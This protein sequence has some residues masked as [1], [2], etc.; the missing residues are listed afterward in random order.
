MRGAVGLSGAVGL[1]GEIR[2]TQDTDSIEVPTVASPARLPLTWRR[3]IPLVS[4]LALTMAAWLPLF[5]Q[6]VSAHQPNVDDYFYAY[7]AQEIWNGSVSFLHTGQT[8]PLVPTLAAPL[9]GKFGLNGGVFVQLPLLLLTVTGAYLLAR[10][11]IRPIPAA[12]T[13]LAVGINQA[14]IGYAV[15]LHFSIAV[16]GA[17]I[18]AFYSYLRS[19]HLREPRWCVALGVA[20]AALLLSR[21]MAPSYALP[22]LLVL[23]IDVVLDARRRR[24][25]WATVFVPAVVVLL[26]AGPWWLVSGHAALQYLSSAGYDT[27]TGFSAQK[28]GLG[29]SSIYQ[30]VLW[31]LDELAWPQS[32]ALGIAVLAS[33]WG[34]A[35]YRSQLNYRALWLI[36]VWILLTVLVLSSSGDDG[37]GFGVPVVAMTILACGAVLGQSLAFGSRS[38]RRWGATTL[39]VCAV[40]L[41]GLIAEGTGGTSLWWNGP[42]YRVQVLENG[43]SRNTNLDAIAAQVSDIVGR[44]PTLEAL[45]TAFLSG[46]SLTWTTRQAGLNLIRLP[47]SAESTKDAIAALATAKFIIS[48][49]SILPYPPPVD[50]QALEIA[51]EA[52]NFRPIRTWI[53][54]ADT[55]L[56]LW[57]QSHIPLPSNDFAPRSVRVVKP[58]PGVVMRGGEYLAANVSG[59]PGIPAHV[60][61]LE[62]LVSG[63][64]FHDAPVGAGV[65]FGY[66]WLGAWQ[67]SEFPNGRYLVS[68]IAIT[69][70]HSVRSQGVPVEV[71]N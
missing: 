40:L 65:R 25:R 15:M 69:G 62:F 61:K 70:S 31:D 1:R 50:E 52:R 2:V 55:T 4:V 3:C 64:G 5:L 9:V 28:G 24:P 33:L 29:P 34:V 7:L 45:S 51:A 18:W 67:T 19:D 47:D 38:R 59:R 68:C 43:G 48:G 12:L 60:T 13:A 54:G 10:T 46:N 37:S 66:G 17:I 42:P 39:V 21:S 32:I 53:F 26:L 71:K 56:V 36:L 20:L 41:I 16:T 35:K 63:Q 58:V 23:F 30:H 22:L 11:W 57:K 27:S 14:V 44:Q 49:S 6:R 8:S